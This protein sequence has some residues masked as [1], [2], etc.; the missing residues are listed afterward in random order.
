MAVLGAVAMM[1]AIS[2][3]VLFWTVEEG[4]TA[5]SQG[6]NTFAHTWEMWQ[7]YKKKKKKEVMRWLQPKMLRC[8]NMK[9]RYFSPSSPPCKQRPAPFP[10]R[11]AH[12][13]HWGLEMHWEHWVS[14]EHCGVQESPPESRRPHWPAS[15][16]RGT[17][18]GLMH[19]RNR[20]ISWK[21]KTKNKGIKAPLGPSYLLQCHAPHTMLPTA[22]RAPG[23]QAEATVL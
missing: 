11:V 20:N 15:H 9:R 8:W 5:V 13:P 22:I 3:F 7:E 16:R 19:Y 10:P 21:C 6:A 1:M 18:D 4:P 23:A 17:K 14:C 12:H 2:T